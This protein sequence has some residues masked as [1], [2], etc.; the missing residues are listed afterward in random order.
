MNTLALGRDPTDRDLLGRYRA[1]DQDAFAALY[2]RHKDAL[3]HHARIL[4]RDDGAAEDLVN[5][6]FLKL[7]RCGDAPASESPTLAP[8][9][10]TVLRRLAVDRLRALAASRERERALSRA[11]VRP[12]EPDADP[13]RVQELNEALNRLPP[14]QFETLLLHVYGGLS[15]QEVA[16]TLGIPLNTAMSRYRYALKKLAESLGGGP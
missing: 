10:H 2:A 15:F 7:I 3:Y 13:F 12:S 5:E 4:V 1:G 6:T 11:W 9:L 16:D 8:F 14:E